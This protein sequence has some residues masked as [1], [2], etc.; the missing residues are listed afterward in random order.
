MKQDWHSFLVK[1]KT[2]KFT[3]Y[4]IVLH[5]Q[6][7]VDKFAQQTAKSAEDARMFRERKKQEVDEQI[8]KLKKERRKKEIKGKL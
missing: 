2:Q 3:S 1:R 7:L 6:V 8:E 4:L 5:L